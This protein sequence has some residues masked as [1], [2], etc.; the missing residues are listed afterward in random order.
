VED[1]FGGDIDYAMLIKLYGTVAGN[2][3]EARYSPGECRTLSAR[4]W[5]T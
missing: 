1:G 3:S 5:R 4:N 2:T